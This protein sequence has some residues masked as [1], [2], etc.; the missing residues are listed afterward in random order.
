MC[1]TVINSLALLLENFTNYFMNNYVERVQKLMEHLPRDNKE[2]SI[3]AF[4][5]VLEG[6]RKI[7]DELSDLSEN[8]IELLWSNYSKLRTI[9]STMSALYQL[10]TQ[11]QKDSVFQE[12]RREINN[13]LETLL[14]IVRR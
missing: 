4:N 7:L 12:A 10:K 13:D 8:Y 1:S 9:E 6:Y 5:T 11:K 14:S 2:T 3:T